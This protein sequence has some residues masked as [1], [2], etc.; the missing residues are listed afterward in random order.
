MGL[1]PELSD[2]KFGIASLQNPISMNFYDQWLAS[3]FHGEMDYLKRHRDLKADPTRWLPM[4]RSAIVFS[5][6][7]VTPKHDI[8]GRET[9]KLRT[10]LYTR[11]TANQSDYHTVLRER[12][13][14]VVQELERR[15]P[16]ETFRMA[17]DTAPILERDLAVRAGLGWVGKNT[18]V[19]DRKVGSLFF[20]AE[21]L[22]SL[23][24]ASDEDPIHGSLISPDFCGTCTRCIDSCPTGALVAPRSLDARKCI[25]YWTIEAKT[26]PPENLAGKFGDWFFGCDICQTVCPWNEKVFG[27]EKMQKEARPNVSGDQIRSDLIEELGN[28]LVASNRD[29]DRRFKNTPMSRSRGFG[30]KRNALIVIGNLKLFELTETIRLLVE[31]PK[32]GALAK[33]TLQKLTP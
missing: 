6:N 31:D 4:A 10:A 15:Y 23:E 22:T 32:L 5:I 7:Y 18:C 14:P 26:V 17:I 8:E 27:R 25:S 20:I 33:S 16:G 3:D 28:L 30:L 19:I 2:A 21:I 11:F 12:L 24:V 13:S 9:S 29:L 1:T